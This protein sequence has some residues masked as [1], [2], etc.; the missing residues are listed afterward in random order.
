MA[1]F[2]VYIGIIPP[3]LVFRLLQVANFVGYAPEYLGV[4]QIARCFDR[5]GF[6][7]IF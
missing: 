4:M 1:W 6:L 3:P 5:L 2:A 7:F